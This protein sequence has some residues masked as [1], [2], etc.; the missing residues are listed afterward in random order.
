V[1]PF[2]D[3]FRPSCVVIN[4]D[5]QIVT[6]FLI[7]QRFSERERW[8]RRWLGGPALRCVTT[9]PIV[10]ASCSAEVTIPG[11]PCA[12]QFSPFGDEL[13]CIY[14]NEIDNEIVV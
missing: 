3:Y 5:I 1:F 2:E 10:T 7:K 8:N 12:L 6:K 9:R 11:V 14:I 4:N 13:K